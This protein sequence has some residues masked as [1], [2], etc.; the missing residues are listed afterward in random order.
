MKRSKGET[1]LIINEV[2]KEILDGK[3]Y[4]EIL[5][6]LKSH[7]EM[8]LTTSRWYYEKADKQILKICEQDKKSIY[9]KQLSRYNQRL[10]RCSQIENPKDRIMTELKVMERIDKINGLEKLNIDITGD[11]DIVVGLDDMPKD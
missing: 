1:Q 10:Y 8:K 11:I 7:Y 2:V 3:T 5:S 9:E 6:Y 4:T